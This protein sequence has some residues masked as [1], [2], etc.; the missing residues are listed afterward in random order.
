[1]T[2]IALVNSEIKNEILLADFFDDSLRWRMTLSGTR[3]GL[4]AASPASA[5]HTPNGFLHF[6]KSKDGPKAIGYFSLNLNVAGDAPD[7]ANSLAIL[8]NDAVFGMAHSSPSVAWRKS[9]SCRSLEVWDADEHQTITYPWLP[10][11]H[12]LQ[13]A[14]SDPF[15]FVSKDFVEEL[16]EVVNFYRA[17]WMRKAL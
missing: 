10:F 4:K 16:V 13:R 9:L 8:A 15:G 12:S 7:Y 6:V 14:F 1:M 2:R 17:D 5:L 3:A 11:V